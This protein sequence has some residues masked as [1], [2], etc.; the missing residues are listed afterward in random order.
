MNSETLLHTPLAPALNYCP[1]CGSPL[2]DRHA[3]GQM[4]RY[5]AVCDRVVF[6]EHKV[7]VA[8]VVTDSQN[9]VLLIRRGMPPHQGCWSLPAG[10]VDYNEAPVD[11]ARR[12]CLEETGLIVK[13]G[14]VIEVVS[15]REHA[16]GADIV[17]V[18]EGVVVSGTLM[19]AD[20]ADAAGFFDPAHLPPL[21]FESTHPAVDR[22]CRHL[23]L[24]RSREPR[25]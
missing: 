24:P 9:K 15:G 11:A 19:A 4:R 17:I 23:A 25:E 16:R 20:D 8:L 1:A 21:A 5:C 13:L 10:F 6:R 3:F 14:Q 7:A 18:Y 12:E 22:W 2:E